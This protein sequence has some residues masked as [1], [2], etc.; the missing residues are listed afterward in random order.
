M[1]DFYKEIIR[2]MATAKYEDDLFKVI[3]LMMDYYKSGLI[4]MDEAKN[5]S[6]VKGLLQS[7]MIHEKNK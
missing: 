7:N 2:L 1:E 6:E 4:T 3:S 5:I